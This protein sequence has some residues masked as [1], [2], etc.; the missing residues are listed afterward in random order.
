MLNRIALIVVVL[1]ATLASTATAAP[2]MAMGGWPNISIVS[3]S[4]QSSDATR[5]EFPPS[6]DRG[7]AAAPTIPN[8][9]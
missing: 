7:V 2:T 3:V 8:K 6:T 4:A 5:K 9:I 1:A